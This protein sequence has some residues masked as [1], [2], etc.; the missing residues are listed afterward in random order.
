MRVQAR[1]M[2]A[3]VIGGGPAGLI[4]ALDLARAG[5][6]V[7]ILDEQPELGGQFF[8]QRSAEVRDQLG[9][10][11]PRGRQ[12]V[13]AVRGAGVTC[14][15]STTVWGAESH[16]LEVLARGATGPVIGELTTRAIVVATGASEREIPFPGWQVPGVMSA[17]M[18]QH[19]A[20]SEGVRVGR[21]AVVAG[22]GPFLVPAA[23]ELARHGTRVLAVIEAGTPYLPRPR[24]LAAALFPSRVAQL[25]SSFAALARQGTAIHQGSA[26][27]GAEPGEGGRLA[28]IAV[29]KVDHL[30]AV[31]Y[32]YEVDTLC[33][34]F[35]F[36]PQ[37]EL[38]RLLGCT[39][40][41]EESSHELV[42]VT[43]CLGRTDSEGVY[44]AGEAAG[45]RGV[46]NAL[47]QGH[48]VAAAVL[49]DSGHHP[50]PGRVRRAL[51]AVGHET[52]FARLADDIYPRPAEL[53]RVLL[54]GM[55]GSTQ[56]CRCEGVTLAELQKLREEGCQDLSSVK[57]RSRA[58]MGPCQGRECA[59]A[60]ASMFG[61]SLSTLT[62]RR[63]VRPLPVAAIIEGES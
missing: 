17:G 6:A 1:D 18:A 40:Q 41:E 28:S 30:G 31:R 7:T 52:R 57:T 23:A 58:C 22:S 39:V 54:G 16:R 46:H 44:V 5:Q 20:A 8:H 63:P 11:R 3:I 26:V 49:E 19:L 38:L 37:S 47:A 34:G 48:L 24:A 62:T 33:V 2:D 56:V 32:R 45:V 29:A 55:P 15:T 61:T 36:R 14:M 13:E 42:P 9:E 53:A 10:H 51:R 27:V 25:A 12:L 50:S 21:R 4:A 59:F 60:V 35:G 43:D